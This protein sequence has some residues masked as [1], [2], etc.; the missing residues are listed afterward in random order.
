MEAPDNGAAAKSSAERCA[1]VS[2]QRL[3]NGT[4][5]CAMGARLHQ[6]ETP[7][8]RQ[9]NEAPLQAS[10]GDHVAANDGASI[11]KVEDRNLGRRFRT[12]YRGRRSK[13]PHNLHRAYEMRQQQF[14]STQVL[15]VQWT[16]T[17]RS[18]QAE[19]EREPRLPAFVRSC[20][21]SSRSI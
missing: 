14:E 9:A 13:P 2:Y 18:L 5:H 21:L 6:G 8:R 20:R 4:R 16:L 10:L 19:T 7:A 15:M 11:V 3:M 17:R 1:T 12:R